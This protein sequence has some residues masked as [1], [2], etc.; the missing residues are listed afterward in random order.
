MLGV[1]RNFRILR[2]VE[3]PLNPLVNDHF[4]D[5][6]WTSIVGIRQFQLP[7]FPK[8]GRNYTSETCLGHQQ[9]GSTN[10][11]SC[12]F[13]QMLDETLE[14]HFSKSP[15]LSFTI[16]IYSEKWLAFPSEGH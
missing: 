11:C 7:K 14:K 13:A 2:M 3:Y 5:R 1:D 9:E 12:L 6:N 15:L 8:T 16:K 4:P 10:I